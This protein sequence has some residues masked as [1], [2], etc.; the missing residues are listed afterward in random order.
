MTLRPIV[1]ASWIATACSSSGDDALLSGLGRA[2]EATM[3]SHLAE[4]AVYLVVNKAVVYN[5]EKCG[6]T[7]SGQD[8]VEARGPIAFRIS[9]DLERATELAFT[10]PLADGVLS[11]VPVLGP[12]TAIL[13]S[14]GVVGAGEAFETLGYGQLHLHDGEQSVSVRFGVLG[15]V[16]LLDIA[17]YPRGFVALYVDE[18]GALWRF[19]LGATRAIATVDPGSRIV[20]LDTSTVVLAHVDTTTHELVIEHRSTIDGTVTRTVPRVPIGVDVVRVARLRANGTPG[21]FRVFLQESL[22]DIVMRVTADAARFESQLRTKTVLTRLGTVGF[23]ASSLVGDELVVDDTGE[24]RVISLAS[25]LGDVE[26]TSDPEV[27]DTCGRRQYCRGQRHVGLAPDFGGVAFL[28]ESKYPSDTTVKVSPVAL[29]PLPELTADET[30]PVRIVSLARAQ[31]EL[32]EDVGPDLVVRTE[33]PPV[34]NEIDVATVSFGAA[35]SFI[36]VPRKGLIDDGI[37][38]DVYPASDIAPVRIT[39]RLPEFP[40]TSATVLLWAQPGAGLQYEVYWTPDANEPPTFALQSDLN[41]STGYRWFVE[42]TYANCTEPYC[43]QTQC[44]VANRAVPGMPALGQPVP[45]INAMWYRTR[46][47]YSA[48]AVEGMNACD[49]TVMFEEMWT[50]ADPLRTRIVVAHALSP[51]GAAVLQLPGGP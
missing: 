23:Q 3:W 42:N 45:Q 4:D 41:A 21:D 12:G 6:D 48:T 7:V 46:L 1:L 47:V 16:P 14:N 26:C 36:E 5:P 19:E 32:G 30:I 15:D 50:P 51:S 2:G 25:E 40:V 37:L 20:S 49:G 17:A 28:Y 34:G 11:P 10:E 44:Y 13:A 18:N 38:F 31:T 22:R 35:S 43:P 39:I 8:V 29:R 33:R 9:P 24:A 27:H